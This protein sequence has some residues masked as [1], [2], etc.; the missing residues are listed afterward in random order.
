[1]VHVP[2]ANVNVAHAQN[3]RN[4]AGAANNLGAD[5]PPNNLT[6][7]PHGKNLNINPPID[8]INGNISP[9]DD[10]FVYNQIDGTPTLDLGRPNFA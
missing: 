8:N 6:N 7:Q 4:V 5:L 3:V 2:P 10:L 9:I 1:M